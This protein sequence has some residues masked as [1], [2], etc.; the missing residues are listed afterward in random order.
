M[1]KE[2]RNVLIAAAGFLILAVAAFYFVNET[3]E[4]VAKKEVVIEGLEGALV[5]LQTEAARR[6]DLERQRDQLKGNFSQYIKILPSAEVATPEELINVIQEKCERSQ[7]VLKQIQYK[8]ATA[9]NR[10]KKGSTQAFQELEVVLQATGTYGQFV[11]FL[12]LME[13][14]PSFLRVNTFRCMAPGRPLIDPEGNEFYPLNIS[15]HISTF[16]YQAAS[17]KKKK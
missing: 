4:E 3:K 17:G 6:E 14:N 7:L 15:L 10:G 1:T 5:K 9:G 16:R 2:L 13:R 8:P 12:N 11:R